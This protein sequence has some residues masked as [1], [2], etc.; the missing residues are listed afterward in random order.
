[1]N[2][3]DYPC[4]CP[5]GRT[6]WTPVLDRCQGLGRFTGLT[7]SLGLASGS[8]CLFFLNSIKFNLIFFLKKIYIGQLIKS[9]V[10]YRKY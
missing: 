10:K 2:F 9:S 8:A 6:N 3:S 1:M 7:F 5:L 4:Y